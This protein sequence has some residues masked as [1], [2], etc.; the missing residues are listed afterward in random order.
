MINFDNNF[1][2]IIFYE[3]SIKIL[4]LIYFLNFLSIKPIGKSNH[5]NKSFFLIFI[6]YRGIL[7]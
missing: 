6:L 7:K 5:K 2:M 3:N 1:I 4:T